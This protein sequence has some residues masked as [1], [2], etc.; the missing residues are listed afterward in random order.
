M[1]PQYKKALV[2][3]NSEIKSGIFKLSIENIHGNNEID[4]KPGQFYMLRC[5]ERDPLLSRP[6]SIC[7]VSNETLTFLY[8]ALG[9]GTKLLSEV[10]S[11]DTI[12]VLGPLGNG[13]NPEAISGKI[14]IVAGGIGIAPMVQLVKE[15]KNCSIDVYAGF[16]KDVYAVEEM[17]QWVKDIYISTEDGSTG[18]KGYV[19][20]LVT[21]DKYDKVL[22]C[23]PEVMMEK[24][25]KLCREKGVP[26]YV[27]MEKHMAC[28]VGACLVCTCKTKDGNKRTCKD[29]PVFSGDDLI[30]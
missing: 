13:F 21:V 3:E 2:I 28:G 11:G 12:E 15:L 23:G 1:K 27:S 17:K 20:D 6:I 26:I 7:E 8:A 29:G 16:R 10:K 4:I 18:Y 30:F 5:W 19:T 9:R 22:C 24:V 25:V 14:A